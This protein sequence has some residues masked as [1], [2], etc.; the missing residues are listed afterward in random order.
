MPR[1][2][3]HM[4]ISGG[5][6]KSFARGESVGLDAMQIF[7]KNERQWTAKPISAEE[8]AAFQAEQQRTGIHPVIVHDSYLINL[9]APADDLR[10][11]SIAAFADELERCAQL[12]IP[13]LVTH[14]GAHTGIGEEAGLV[15]VADAISRL[16]AEGVG[17]TTM[18]LLET[19]AGQGTALGYRF[20][21]LARLFELIPYHDRL[22][23]CVDTCHIFAAG[24]DIR[25]PDTYDA[26]F[27]ELD[28]LVGL[29]RV[30][31]FHLNDSQKDLGSRVDRHAHIGQGCIGTEA[32]RLLV[33]DPRF[34]HLPMI[35]ET[36]KG[37]DM[38]EDRMNLAL[39]RS[40]VQI[41]AA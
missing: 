11:K 39:L 27:A 16:L 24:Y 34:A 13:Y 33:N 21:H 29:E 20:E 8:V 9:A 5:V 1:F 37:E 4:S 38:A 19:T 30:K 18:I 22:G 7:A 26:T 2:G 35:I 3:A 10:E 28:R 40:L 15:R 12:K 41:T 36:P 23:I 32:F 17:G 6:S 14:P 31:C 25:D